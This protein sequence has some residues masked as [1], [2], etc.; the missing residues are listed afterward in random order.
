MGTAVAGQR[1]RLTRLSRFSS[2]TA[3][4]SSSIGRTS[5]TP[6]ASMSLKSGLALLGAQQGK[7]PVAEGADAAGGDVG[8]L[9]REVGAG[10]AA[11]AGPG[12]CLLERD[13]VVAAVAHPHL[14]DALDVHLHDL[15]PLQAVLGLEELGEDGVVEGLRA[16]QADRQR[17]APGDLSGLAGLHDA[18]R[19]GLAAHADEGDASAPPSSASA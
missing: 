11:L 12:V 15:G 9:G 8:V 17:E 7:G 3:P 10:L 14:E 13:L 5:T 16:E 19:R 18:G 4:G 2:S 1:L 6:A